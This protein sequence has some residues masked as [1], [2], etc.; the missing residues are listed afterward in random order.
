MVACVASRFKQ[1]E[2]ERKKRR[3]H[4]KF[5]LSQAPRGFGD[6]YRGFPAFLA[7]SNCIKTAKLRRLAKWQSEIWPEYWCKKGEGRL[8]AECNKNNKFV[9]Q[10]P[11]VF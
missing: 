3:S 10:R 6:P 4:E 1:F 5:S 11:T 8:M 2:R 7:P 9:R